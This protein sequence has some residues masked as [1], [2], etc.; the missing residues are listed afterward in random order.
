MFSG[1][2]HGVDFLLAEL[3]LLIFHIFCSMKSASQTYEQ[4][5]LQG[6]HK[7]RIERYAGTRGA[8]GLGIK[9]LHQVFSQ[10]ENNL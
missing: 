5:Y 8:V 1:F 7:E 3:S 2:I 4:V 6:L 10:S 9:A